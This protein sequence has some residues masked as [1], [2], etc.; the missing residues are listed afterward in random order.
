[1][2]CTL[3]QMEGRMSSGEAVDVDQYGRFAGRLCRL[4]ELIGIHRLAKPIDPLTDLAKGFKARTR[5]ADDD[6]PGDDAPLAIEEAVDHEP[7]EA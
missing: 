6:E 3:E 4:F 7:G 2:E 5:A 1:M